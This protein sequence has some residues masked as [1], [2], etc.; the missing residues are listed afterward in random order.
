MPD[1]KHILVVDDESQIPRVLRTSL[2]S[3]GYDIR[4][5][6]DGETALEI[7]KDWTPDLGITVLSM[8][9]M[10]GLELCRRLRLS[11]KIPIIV[12]SVKGEERTKVRALD[13]GADDYVTKPF[14]MEEL[15][16]R[17]RA[18]LRRSRTEASELEPIAAGD[19]K[20]DPGARSVFVK[21]RA[22]HL[23]PKEFDLLAYLVRHAGRVVTDRAL[24]PGV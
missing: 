17:V 24:L 22:V 6:N 9:N 19:F 14:G 7:M 21:D 16:A 11:S 15:L 8:P 20:I 4:V 13:A 23:T 10:D 1:H 18:N 12:L 5:A 3:H 2:S